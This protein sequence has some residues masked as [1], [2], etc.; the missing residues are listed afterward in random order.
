MPAHGQQVKTTAMADAQTQVHAEHA[1][2]DTQR[3]NA[4]KEV[5]VDMR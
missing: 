5:G 2:L 4:E 1:R 3:R